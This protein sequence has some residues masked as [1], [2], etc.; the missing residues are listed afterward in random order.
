MG[1][2]PARCYRKLQ[3]A[4]TRQS[5]RRPRKSYVKGVPRSKIAQFQF[6]NP[7]GYNTI[8]YLVSKKTLQLRHN[9][10]EAARMQI[11]RI[12]EQ[13]IGKDMFFW[14]IR[15]YPH[16][17]LRENPLATGAGADRFQTGMRQSF[18]KPIAT[19]A[20][21]SEGQKIAEIRVNREYVPVA[22]KA[23]KQA[24]YKMFPCKVVIED[25]KG[26]E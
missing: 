12:L 1:L 13:G 8:L 9:S 25:Y 15:V 3:R 10:I 7:K 4:Y 2:R 22:K 14:K 18:G 26:Q 20:V 5:I 23:F 16:Q 21:V 17:I 19:A 24:M 11:S 6:G